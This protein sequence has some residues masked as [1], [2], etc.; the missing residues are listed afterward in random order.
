LGADCFYSGVLNSGVLKENE[1]VSVLMLRPTLYGPGVNATSIISL[2]EHYEFIFRV[3]GKQFGFTDVNVNVSDQSQVHGMLPSQQVRVW[4]GKC[5]HA[6]TLISLES[7]STFQ[8]TLVCDGCCRTICPL[9]GQDRQRLHGRLR[10]NACLDLDLS[11][12]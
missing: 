9:R 8:S 12:L 10:Y 6:W 4:G 2:I 3:L 7:R 11:L 5:R 1:A